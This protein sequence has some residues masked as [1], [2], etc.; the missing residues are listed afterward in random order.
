MHTTNN[1]IS[2]TFDYADLELSQQVYSQF[3]SG[4]VITKR[5]YEIYTQ[6]FIENPLYTELYKHLDSHYSLLYKHIGFELVFNSGG[7]F[8]H[9]RKDDS[10]EDA[11]ENATKVQALLLVIARFWTDK[12]FDLDDLAN[13][14]F[15][16]K[17]KHIDEIKRNEQYDRIRGA[18]MPKDDWD[19]CVRFL[20]NRNFMYRCGDGHYVVSSAGMFFIQHHVKK[21]EESIS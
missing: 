9:I 10:S 17:A 1:L 2:N 12:S 13:E 20:L 16:L 8:F 3:S 15:G 4:K 6:Q 14:H 11:D 21:Y 5:I 18:L 7:E 19:A